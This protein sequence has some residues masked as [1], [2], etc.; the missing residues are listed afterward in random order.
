[1]AQIKPAIKSNCDVTELPEPSIHVAVVI[2]AYRVENHIAEV[3]ALM[4]ALVRT[5]IAVDDK[6]PDD[7]GQL[8]DQLAWSASTIDRHPS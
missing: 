7:T 4:P 2:P 6:S 3:I 5:I 1:M 8:L